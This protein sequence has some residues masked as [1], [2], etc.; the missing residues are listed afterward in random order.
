MTIKEIH[1]NKKASVRKKYILP[2]SWPPSVNTNGFDRELL[3]RIQLYVETMNFQ[4]Q[5]PINNCWL[6]TVATVNTCKQG[7]E[8][9]LQAKSFCRNL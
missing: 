3:N 1:H 2:C 5:R 9:I 8:N 4:S 7:Q 6:L